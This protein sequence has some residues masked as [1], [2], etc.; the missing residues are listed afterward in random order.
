[1]PRFFR[2]GAPSVGEASIDPDVW[3]TD[4]TPTLDDGES[5]EHF[6]DIERLRGLEL[7]R[8]RS[9]YLRLLGRKRIDAAR[10]GFLPYAVVEGSERLAGCFAQHRRWPEDRFIHAKCLL[11]AGWLA[12][13]V[14][15]LAQPLHTTIHYDGRAKRKGGSPHTG[16]HS[17]VD[18]LLG[19]STL[20]PGTANAGLHPTPVAD[21][22][23]AYRAQFRESHALVD[24]V[25]E[26][27]RHL[28]RPDGW[29]HPAATAFATER[30][31]AGVG[32]LSGLFVWAWERSA[33]I[34]LPGWLER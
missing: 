1:V 32:L 19:R 34:E 2:E 6:L 31:R 28:R 17:R 12:H 30:Y 24:S 33:E 29:R 8:R 14:G 11:W 3:K 23:S 10:T 5:P 27:D 16:L 25:Y 21:P 22:W 15:D 7:P 4:A 20:D 18:G 9:D 26:L 13:Y